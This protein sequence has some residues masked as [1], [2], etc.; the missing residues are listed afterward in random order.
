[1][2][3][4]L[5]SRASFYEGLGF[6]PLVPLQGRGRVTGTAAMFVAL[7]RISAAMLEPGTE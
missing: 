7:R 4:A 1:V 2:V 6:K 5:D 3:D